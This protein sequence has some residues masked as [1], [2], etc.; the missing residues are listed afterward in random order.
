MPTTLII[1]FMVLLLFVSSSLISADI[2]ND[3]LELIRATAKGLCSLQ[4][5]DGAW[6]DPN[7]VLL[8]PLITPFDPPGEKAAKAKSEVYDPYL[9]LLEETGIAAAALRSVQDFYPEAKAHADKALKL[10]VN[11]IISH[12]NQPISANQAMAFLRLHPQISFEDSE[13]TKAVVIRCKKI[14]AEE[15]SRLTIGCIVGN[16]RSECI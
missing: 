13:D 15:I 1:R 14:I 12:P 2:K 16:S 8:I 10:M 9:I 3:T 5:E 7:T 6:T 11:S 4:Q